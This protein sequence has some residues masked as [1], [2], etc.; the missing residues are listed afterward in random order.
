M[1]HTKVWMDFFEISIESS[2]AC[3]QR[4]LN[5]VFAYKSYLFHLIT[6][7]GQKPN[8]ALVQFQIAAIYIFIVLGIFSD[9]L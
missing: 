1:V 6:N 2:P 5:F 7:M 4:N 3:V 8:Q 9:Y